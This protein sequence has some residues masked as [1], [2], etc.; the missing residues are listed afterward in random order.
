MNEGQIS[1]YSN[2]SKVSSQCCLISYFHARKFRC[3]LDTN[4]KL[5]YCNTL[6]NSKP[7][8]AMHGGIAQ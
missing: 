2:Y 1:N 3:I 8:L 7:N 6:I 5:I 4:L